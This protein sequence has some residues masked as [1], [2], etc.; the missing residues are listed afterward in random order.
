VAKLALAPNST[1]RAKGRVGRPSESARPSAS[2][3]SSTT[4][5]IGYQTNTLVYQLGG[6]RFRDFLVVGLPL[7]LLVGVVALGLLA[8]LYP[9]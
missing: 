3:I 4:T 8:V 1:A 5:P 7:K 9:P 2:G 6:Y